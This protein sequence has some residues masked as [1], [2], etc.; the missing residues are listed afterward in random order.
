LTKVQLHAIGVR[1]DAGDIPALL[2]EI[3]RLRAIVLRVD[4]LQRVLGSLGGGAGV[5]LAG[6]QRE[7]QGEPC[8]VEQERLPGHGEK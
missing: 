3:K 7:L 5:L 6:L 8:V 1:K 4:Q 2:W